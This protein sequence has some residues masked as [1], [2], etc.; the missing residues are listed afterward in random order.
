MQISH[1]I[2]AM[3]TQ[4]ALRLNNAAMCKSLERLSTGLKIN[5]AQ[6]GIA[7]ANTLPLSVLRFWG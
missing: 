5:H 4:N 1:N 2:S 3:V 7:P 6:D